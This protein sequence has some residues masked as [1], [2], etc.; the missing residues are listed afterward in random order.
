LGKKR[1]Q[2]SRDIKGLIKKQALKREARG[3]SW[4]RSNEYRLGIVLLPPIQ[5]DKAKPEKKVAT[6]PRKKPR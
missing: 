5:R 3:N 1:K 4:G 2:V 6:K